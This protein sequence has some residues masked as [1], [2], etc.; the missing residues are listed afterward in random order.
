MT[1]RGLPLIGCA[2]LCVAFFVGCALLLFFDRP[3]LAVR[4]QGTLITGNDQTQWP[5]RARPTPA[6]PPT[7]AD[8]AIPVRPNSQNPN[9]KALAKAE[10]TAYTCGDET[11]ADPFGWRLCLATGSARCGVGFVELRA[12]N[13]T[14]TCAQAEARANGLSDGAAL[15]ESAETAHWIRH[16]VGSDAFYMT[17]SSATQRVVVAAPAAFAFTDHGYEDGIPY[18]SDSLF[19]YADSVEYLGANACAYRAHFRVSLDAERE[20]ALLSSLAFT[21]SIVR[22]YR[23]FMGVTEAPSP[24]PRPL[25]MSS[26]VSASGM[27]QIYPFRTPGNLSA[28]C[29]RSVRMETV[30]DRRKRLDGV[31][32]DSHAAPSVGMDPKTW[33]C[34]ASTRRW[35]WRPYESAGVACG[36]LLARRESFVAD[37]P[38]DD[39]VPVDCRANA[40]RILFLGDSTTRFLM[41]GLAM[42][43]RHRANIL[44]DGPDWEVLT[45][46]VPGRN[47]STSQI[48][49]LERLYDP[50]LELLHPMRAPNLT[51]PNGYSLPRRNLW[52]PEYARFESV[53]QDLQAGAYDAVVFQA[54]LWCL[55]FAD[56]HG[57]AWSY[58]AYDALWRNVSRALSTHW[59]ASLARRAASGRPPMKLIWQG[60]VPVSPE[61]TTGYNTL[62][63]IALFEQRAARL[64]APLKIT[65]AVD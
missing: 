2:A 43:L 41:G 3:A 59:T 60:L 20:G 35:R 40:A 17:L 27:T 54:G 44:T 46:D 49:S 34:C 4:A 6:A 61:A 53:A 62:P 58:R 37:L 36:G 39:S 55:A 48:V 57:G 29:A 21:L 32:T 24:L 1:E 28:A 22:L 5:P 52:P 7:D 65:M 26:I 50:H 8:S 25:D 14:L 19:A 23:D 42:R 9:T 10:S 11:M 33:A 12:R 45:V 38:R 15:S 64:L 18:A 30:C 63:R 56:K 47:S 13:A 16:R 51:L 31:W